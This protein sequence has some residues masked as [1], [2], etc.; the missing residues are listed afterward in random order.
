[1]SDVNDDKE[2]TM[3]D[4]PLI[5]PDE[6]ER[7]ALTR[8]AFYMM[9]GRESSVLPSLRVPIMS[10]ASIPGLAFESLRLQGRYPDTR[11][12][13]YFR[14]VTRCQYL[15]GWRRRFWWELEDWRARGSEE[16][17][18]MRSRPEGYGDHI[19]LEF[20]ED[21]DIWDPILPPSEICIPDGVTWMYYRGRAPDFELDQELSAPWLG[22]SL[23]S[24]LYTPHSDQ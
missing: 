5:P 17:T 10:T 9:I 11:L 12:A 23:D 20:F 6:F 3:S 16:G 19:W 8:L 21:F 14:D 1:M 4:T 13:I 24:S 7:R 2:A 18:R 22:P 15:F